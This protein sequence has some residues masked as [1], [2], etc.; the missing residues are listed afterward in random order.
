MVNV[1]DPRL[2]GSVDP[3]HC[4]GI[5]LARTEFLFLGEGGLPDEDAQH[6]VYARLVEW[7]AG[8]PVTV[9]TLDAGGDKP[10]AGLTMV[11]ETNPFLGFRGVRLS[12]SR[13]DVFKVQL[14]A[15]ARAA[16]LG[17]VKVMIPMEIGRAHV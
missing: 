10:V 5:G 4:D 12:L 2:L 13:P 1:D 11:G 6:R 9:R 14:R 15:L 17:P 16:V 7:S 8:R 3:T